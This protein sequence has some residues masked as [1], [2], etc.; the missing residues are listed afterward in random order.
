VCYGRA[1][2]RPPTAIERAATEDF[3]AEVGQAIQDRQVVQNH[4]AELIAKEAKL[5]QDKED[6]I[7]RLEE[8]VV[9]PPPRILC[10]IMLIVFSW[11]YYQMGS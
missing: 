4:L 11:S 3:R 2:P 1:G 6:V 10:R 5:Q 8:Y 7:T 9:L